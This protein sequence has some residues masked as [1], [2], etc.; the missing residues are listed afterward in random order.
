MRDIAL[1]LIFFGALTYVF[2]RPYIGIYLWTWLSLMNPHRLTYGFA[3]TFPFAQIVALATLA[4]MLVS[5]E[6]KRLP[7]T[8]ET[9]VM[10]VF[11][12]W[13]LF[14]TVFAMYPELAWE[15][16]NKVWKI[17][18]MVYITLMLINSRQKLD[19]LLWVPVKRS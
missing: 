5:K 12:L 3:F 11:I 14:T 16:W 18:L 13:M 10:L 9:V 19:W 6:P 2:S 7:W 4:S 15:Q 1:T 17:M 8:R